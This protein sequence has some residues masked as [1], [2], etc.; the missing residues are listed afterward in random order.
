MKHS[1]QQRKWEKWK[2][3]SFRFKINLW[4]LKKLGLILYGYF[5]MVISIILTIIIYQLIILN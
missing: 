4:L 1:F 2:I 5:I 3:F